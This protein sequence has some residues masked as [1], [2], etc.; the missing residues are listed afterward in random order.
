MR[1]MSMV[2]VLTMATG[3][4][5]EMVGGD[6][7]PLECTALVCSHLPDCA[8]FLPAMGWDWRSDEACLSTMTCGAEP[9]ACAEAVFALPCVGPGPLPPAVVEAVH[10]VWVECGRSY[11]GEGWGFGTGGGQG[12]ARKR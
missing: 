1:K 4:A 5:D 2:L 8:P 3:C 12:A 6:M 9:S 10:R 11:T 7:A